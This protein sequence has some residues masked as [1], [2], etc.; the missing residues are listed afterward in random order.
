M[1]N[2]KSNNCTVLLA[3]TMSPNP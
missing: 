3:E 2:H 1:T